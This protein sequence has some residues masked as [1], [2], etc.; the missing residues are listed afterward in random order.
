MHM[1]LKDIVAASVGPGVLIG[2]SQEG[3]D[4][5]VGDLTETGGAWRG[6]VTGTAKRSIY[7]V[8]MDTECKTELSGTQQIEL[9]GTRGTYA[10]GTNFR[11]GL[12]PVKPPSYT[13]YPKCNYAQ[14]RPKAKNGI[15]W[16]DFYFDAYQGEGLDVHLPDRPGGT[17]EKKDMTYNARSYSPCGAVPYELARCSRDT[18]LTVTYK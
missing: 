14:T 13:S 17:W 10:E 9:V 3:F 8:V 15:E 6:V 12:S 16:L 1:I 11:L 5:I 2:A 18:T 7:T 4:Q